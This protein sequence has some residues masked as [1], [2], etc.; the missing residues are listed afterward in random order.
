MATARSNELRALAQRVADAL[1][2][3]VVEELVL[4]CSASR[5]TADEVSDIQM[6]VVTREPS[7]LEDCFELATPPTLVTSSSAPAATRS[8]PLSAAPQPPCVARQQLGGRSTQAS[9]S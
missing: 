8:T 3:D 7:E 4:T 2:V 5:G 9:D 1:P 6:L